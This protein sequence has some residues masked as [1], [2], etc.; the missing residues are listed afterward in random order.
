MQ[1][2]HVGLC[3]IYLIWYSDEDDF[4]LFVYEC[5]TGIDGHSYILSGRLTACSSLE[6]LNFPDNI[7]EKIGT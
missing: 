3:I 5:D 2:I 7:P 4:S 1:A 6:I